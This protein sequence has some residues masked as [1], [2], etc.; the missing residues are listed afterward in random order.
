MNGQ[1]AFVWLTGDVFMTGNSDGKKNRNA[2]GGRLARVKRILFEDFLS[3][4][5]AKQ[6]DKH[7]LVTK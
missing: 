7:H 4:H 6:H 5:K 3:K 2:A 1:L